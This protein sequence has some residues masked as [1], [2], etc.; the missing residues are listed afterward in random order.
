MS[1]NRAVL[2]LGAVAV[3]G[4]ATVG[5][6]AAYAH[7]QGKPVPNAAVTVGSTW[8]QIKPFCYNGGKV[9]TVKQLAACNATIEK[10]L[11]SGDVPTITVPSANA[12]F[13]INLDQIAADNSWW[14]KYQ[15]GVLVNTTKDTYAG[16]L[17][18]TTVL[19]STSQQTGAATVGTSGP[20]LVSEGSGGLTSAGGPIYGEWL[21]QLKV[22]GS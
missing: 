16:P 22:K 20:V 1:L 8:T 21:F 2:A 11:T 10:K 4:V 3:V 18:A 7:H 12:N 5:A 13:S 15:G 6:S 9:I 17:S 14:A 19:T